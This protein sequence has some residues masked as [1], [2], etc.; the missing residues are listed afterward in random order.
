MKEA[1][2]RVAAIRQPPSGDYIEN[3]YD[4]RGTGEMGMIMI[5]YKHVNKFGSECTRMSSSLN[6]EVEV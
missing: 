3:H 6:C 5:P 1:G 4:H 2:R